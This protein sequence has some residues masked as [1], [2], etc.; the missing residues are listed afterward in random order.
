M[1]KVQMCGI[2]EM[3]G[4]KTVNWKCTTDNYVILYIIGPTKSGWVNTR[5]S[6]YP[7]SSYAP[8]RISKRLK[9]LPESYLGKAR[10]HQQQFMRIQVY[11]VCIR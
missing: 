5:P 1:S 8:G 3:L 6:K 9:I 2:S 11:V 7:L 4:R 10:Q